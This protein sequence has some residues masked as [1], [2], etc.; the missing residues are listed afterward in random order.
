MFY[1]YIYKTRKPAKWEVCVDFKFVGT[2]D[3]VED[4]EFDSLNLRFLGV[5]NKE[6]FEIHKK[7]GYF[8]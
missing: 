4:K 8:E 1:W 6:E 5:M 2:L 7:L 3:E